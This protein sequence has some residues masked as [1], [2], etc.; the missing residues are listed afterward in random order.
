MSLTAIGAWVAIF[1]LATEPF[2]QQ[3]VTFR[4]TVVFEDSPRVRIPFAQRWDAGAE[5]GNSPDVS[6]SNLNGKQPAMCKSPKL[7]YVQAPMRD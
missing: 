5:Y 4:D 3:L 2:I 6:S 1:S 7:T